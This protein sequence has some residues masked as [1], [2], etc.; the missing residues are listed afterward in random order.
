MNKPTISILLILTVILTACSGTASNAAGPAPDTPNGP[1]AG[2]LSASM[3]VA[4]G[5]IKLDGTSNAV[6][7]EQAGE[8]L[9]LWETLQVLYDS[10]TAATQEIDALVQQ[11]RDTMTDEQLQ[12]IASMNLTRQDMFSIMQSQGQAVGGSQNGNLAGGSPSNNRGEGFGP[13]G[14]GFPA[15]PPPDGG[16]FPGGGPGFG[17]QGQ[18]TRPQNSNPGGNNSSRLV[19]DPNRVP[20]PLVQAVIEYL[21]KI[22]T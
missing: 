14:G 21:Q 19:L 2:E 3:Q 15:G 10:D 12:S 22:G 5:T 17:G 6:T 4:I 18:G 1:A 8:L 13:G 11:I 9:P 16:G 20:T 7:T